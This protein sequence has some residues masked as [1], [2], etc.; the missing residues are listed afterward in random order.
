MRQGMS[1]PGFIGWYGPRP[2]IGDRPHRHHFQVFALDT[3]L[4]MIP[5]ATREEILSGMAGHVLAKG[6]IVGTYAQ[7]RAPTKP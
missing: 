2:P 5:G 4:T 6:E 1:Q 7:T 3:E